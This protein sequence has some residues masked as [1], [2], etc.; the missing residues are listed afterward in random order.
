MLDFI[1]ILSLLFTVLILSYAIG[2][3]PAFRLAIH[4]FIGISAGYVTAIVLLQVI[5]NKMVLPLF[6]GG[7][8][9]KILVI[10][11]LILGVFL[12]AKISQRT[13]W[14]GR[15]V[16]AF[17]VGT[18]AAAA[19]AGALTG[20]LYPQVTGSI[21]ALDP[22]QNLPVGIVILLGTVATLAYFQFTLLGKKAP[23]GRR[24]WL[25]NAIAVVGQVFIAITLGALFAGVFSAALAALIDRIQSIV[26]FI[27]SFLAQILY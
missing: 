15:P 22:Q 3:N 7:T 20:T 27:D 26:L 18:G 9:E 2:D 16:V 5:A 23:T 21:D 4:T 13:E 12:L 1:S 19:V 14:M 8:T 10:V 11:P 25:I 24:G 6:A 17:L